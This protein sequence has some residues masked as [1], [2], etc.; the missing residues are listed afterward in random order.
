VAQ[1]A[2][3]AS[4]HV[5]GLTSDARKIPVLRELGID[6]PVDL[7]NESF[8]ARCSSANIRAVSTS[9]TIR[10]VVKFSTPSSIISPCAVASSS[11]AT[12]PDLDKAIEHVAQ[13]RIYRKLYWKSA[14]VRGFQNQ[15]FPEYFKTKRRPAS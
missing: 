4:C 9:L 3:F 10:W 8:R 11:A 5:I 12:R 13:P 1:I 6:R 2:K 14:S 7:R 15:A